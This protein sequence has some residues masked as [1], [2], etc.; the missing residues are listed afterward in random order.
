MISSRQNRPRDQSPEEPL[1]AGA[2]PPSLGVMAKLLPLL[3]RLQRRRS[4]EREAD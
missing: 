2:I 4:G 1:E 3:R